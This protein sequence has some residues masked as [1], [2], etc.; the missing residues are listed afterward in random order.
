M[1]DMRNMIR[2]P[3]AAA[4]GMIALGS[5]GTGAATAADVPFPQA[6]VRP[7][8]PNDYAPPPVAEGYAYP[9]PAVYG[10]PPPPPTV[11]YEY[12]PPPAVIVP[13]PYYFGP[14]YVYGWRPYARWGYGPYFARGY[15]DDG[16]R[17]GRGFRR[18]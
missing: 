10:Y 14:R 13:R 15:G 4:L 7:P 12:A 9:P 3:L 16:R 11:Y 2:G 1:R 17:W 5:V 18:W 8:P 6:Q